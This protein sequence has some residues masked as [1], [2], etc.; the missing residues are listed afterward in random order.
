MATLYRIF[1]MND[2]ERAM[3]NINNNNEQEEFALMARALGHPHRVTILRYL[4][5]A[6]SCICGNIVEALPIAQSTVSAHLKKLKEA[7]WI[8]GEIEGPRT[9]YCVRPEALKR[10]LLLAQKFL[11][12][13]KE[14][15]S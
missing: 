9:C 11:V 3:D 12:E 7:G 5:E 1:T 13:N 15:C 4:M 10:F 14:C 2:L 8:H 6:N